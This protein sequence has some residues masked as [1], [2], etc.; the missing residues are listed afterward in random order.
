MTA[1]APCPRPD[2]CACGFAEY[3][4]DRIDEALK[5][6]DA[7][8]AGGNGQ[9]LCTRVALIEQSHRSQRWLLRSMGL[10]FMAML[11]SM[12]HEFFWR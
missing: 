5:K 2:D 4:L 10:G 6:L 9:G 3:R 1:P 12:V 11:G 8:I 7:K